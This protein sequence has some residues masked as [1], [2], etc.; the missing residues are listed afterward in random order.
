MGMPGSRLLPVN[1]EKIGSYMCYMAYKSSKYKPCIWS[2]FSSNAPTKFEKPELC[3]LQQ[4]FA[5]RN[6]LT[7]STKTKIRVLIFLL[8]IFFFGCLGCLQHSIVVWFPFVKQYKWHA[9]LIWSDLYDLFR[10]LLGV[11]LRLSFLS[12]LLLLGFCSLPLFLCSLL[13]FSLR[14]SFLTWSNMVVLYANPFDIYVSFPTPRKPDISS[15][16]KLKNKERK[17]NCFYRSGT[18]ELSNERSFQHC[19]AMGAITASRGL[20]TIIKIVYRACCFFFSYPEGRETGWVGLHRSK[21]WI[22]RLPVH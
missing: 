17:P 10:S 9:W 1:P 8:L 20:N 14:P 11:S 6:S 12:L 7:Q 3:K 16:P 5:T 2:L 18:L 22:E 15:I 21:S 19:R 4:T 13:G